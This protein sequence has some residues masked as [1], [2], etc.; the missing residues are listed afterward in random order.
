MSN[1]FTNGT[2][3]THFSSASVESYRV[4]GDNLIL[5]SRQ[6][7]EST[8]AGGEDEL[9]QATEAAW[10]RTVEQ[11]R[12]RGTDVVRIYATGLYQELSL[13]EATHLVSDFYIETGRYFN[14]VDPELEAFY[15]ANAKG[16]GMLFGVAVQE[17]RTVTVCGSFKQSLDYIREIIAKI[18]A[19]GAIVL[20]PP[21]TR[22]NPETI[23]TDFVLFDY[24]DFVKNDRDTW[25]HK[26]I[27]MDSFR[28]A[29]ATI[30][31]NPGGRVGQGTMF[32]L[33]FMSAIPCRT[34][35][36]EE[37]VDLSVKFPC[38]VGLAF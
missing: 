7:I 32:E 11:V 9:I 1:L 13:T 10:H 5:A 6:T 38:E 37:P 36:T 2:I 12:P 16:A 23:G 3:L 21:S 33:G 4:H 34:I 29:D 28:R 22:I 19:S 14:I 31:C 15:S 24:Q 25:R 26:Y 17:F 27:H 8:L 30:V 35:F 18:T 20:S